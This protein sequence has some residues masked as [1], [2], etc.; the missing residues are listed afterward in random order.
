M[1]AVELTLF[2]GYKLQWY[3]RVKIMNESHGLEIMSSPGFLFP[4]PFDPGS[5]QMNITVIHRANHPHPNSLL[6]SCSLSA[7]LI[8]S[9][10]LVM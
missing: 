3:F 5:A 9:W 1:G 10:G 8:F 4:Q 7:F 2:L 6:A